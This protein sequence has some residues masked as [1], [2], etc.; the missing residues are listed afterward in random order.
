MDDRQHDIVTK[1]IEGG[2]CSIICGFA[3]TGK[4][5]LIRELHRRFEGTSRPRPNLPNRMGVVS[6]CAPTGAA[7]HNIQ[8]LTVHR[9]FNI[10]IYNEKVEKCISRIK[11]NPMVKDAIVD[12]DLL[13]I[14]EMTLLS[15]DTLE[16]ID[17]I[18]KSV[19]RNPANFGGLQVV[20]VGDPLQLPPVTDRKLSASDADKRKNIVGNSATRNMYF[21]REDVFTLTKVYRQE[22]KD[23]GELLLSVG[24]G[25][26]TR[27][28]RNKFAQ[29]MM[30][31]S[32]EIPEGYTCLYATN[33]K[34]DAKNA[35]E[36]N[37]LTGE[38]RKYDD[39]YVYT[40]R[41][42]KQR[43][44]GPDD[45]LVPA[46]LT[47]VNKSMLRIAAEHHNHVLGTLELKVGAFVMV[48]QNSGKDTGIYNG[49]TGYIVR[50]PSTTSNAVY[51]CTNKKKMDR[52]IDLPENK[53]AGFLDVYKIDCVG[54]LSMGTFLS[55]HGRINISRFPLKMAY[56]LTTHKSQGSEFDK[57]YVDCDGA[58]QPGQLYTAFT[59]AKDPN[60]FKIV[61]MPH[62]IPFSR[63]AVDFYLSHPPTEIQL[64]AHPMH[65]S[66]PA[67]AA[68]R[69]V[70]PPHET[71]TPVVTIPQPMLH[72]NK[73]TT[74]SLTSSPT[75][76]QFTQSSYT[77]QTNV[78]SAIAPIDKYTDEDY[79]MI[80]DWED[81]DPQS[82]IDGD[83][84][85]GNLV[86]FNPEPVQKKRKL[87]NFS[88]V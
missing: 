48:T 78:T 34:A 27:Y 70:S 26:Y 49:L 52:Y 28:T 71:I 65:T 59:R 63:E 45:Q 17:K 82:Y 11:T 53:Y 43:G 41:M 66:T 68:V 88:K 22:N 25:K 20:L 83:S 36:L 69:P 19:R 57:V 7:A 37:K 77:S 56:A 72:A 18:C 74:P 85:D 61:N 81:G 79:D 2:K 9:V 51:I 62:R 67:P 46:I 86:I 23:F 35:V 54:I 50:L 40:P 24:M 5:T 60:H 44:G 3:G 80:P 10:R 58:T 73:T 84:L 1:I 15:V 12:M 14:D 4:S 16:R 75:Q 38:S 33:A 31:G 13:V 8:G 30:S 55:N 47:E 39:T 29:Y 64:P 76:T 42:V 32:D 21:D 6:L 87:F